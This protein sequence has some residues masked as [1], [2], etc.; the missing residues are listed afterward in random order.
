[1]DDDDD[2]DDDDDYNFLYIAPF[3]ISSMA[4]YNINK[5]KCLE[6]LLKTLYQIAFV[7]L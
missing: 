2:D 7:V 4:P 6:C 3:S 1:M 5:L